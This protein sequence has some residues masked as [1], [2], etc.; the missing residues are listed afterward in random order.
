MI[1]DGLFYAVAAA[2]STG[3][4]Q[5]CTKLAFRSNIGD[6]P[7]GFVVEAPPALEHSMYTRVGLRF[8]GIGT[9]HRPRPGVVYSVLDGI[10]VGGGTSNFSAVPKRRSRFRAVR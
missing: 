7:G 5:I 9:K 10:C 8:V 2:V 1:I 4:H 3:R 6:G